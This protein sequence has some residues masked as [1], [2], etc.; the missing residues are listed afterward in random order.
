MKKVQ[1]GFTVS[2]EVSLK[3]REEAKRAGKKLSAFLGV[4]L[5]AYMQSPKQED[6][7]PPKEA[8]V[9]SKGNNGDCY[10]GTILRLQ[11]RVSALEE[12]VCRL[13]R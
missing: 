4:L 8:P 11:Q 13:M 6:K 12:H 1:M 10:A 2:E 3:Y 5:D 7:L 9:P